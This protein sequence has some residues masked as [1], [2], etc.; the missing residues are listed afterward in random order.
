MVRYLIYLRHY[1]RKAMRNYANLTNKLQQ[2][3]SKS[4]LKFNSKL[5]KRCANMTLGGDYPSLC[6]IPVS[7]MTIPE[8]AIKT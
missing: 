7:G 1:V 2:V 4:E 3:I 8:V 6:H 5:W